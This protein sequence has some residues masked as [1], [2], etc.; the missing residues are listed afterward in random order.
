MKNIK[1]YLRYEEFSIIN[2]DNPF[3]KKEVE[4]YKVLEI[5]IENKEIFSTYIFKKKELQMAVLLIENKIWAVK[6]QFKT[7]A[8]K[9]E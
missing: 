3:D 1:N 6:S 7:E 8:I 2:F 9:I 4:K 5:L